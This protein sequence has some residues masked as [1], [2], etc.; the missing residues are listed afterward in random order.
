MSSRVISNITRN[1][2]LFVGGR[3]SVTARQ[4]SAGIG[5]MHERRWKWKAQL[6]AAG[7]CIS[8]L[9]QPDLQPRQFIVTFTEVSRATTLPYTIR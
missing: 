7:R 5:V 6:V 1:P 8:S 9:V 4:E 2:C 3:E